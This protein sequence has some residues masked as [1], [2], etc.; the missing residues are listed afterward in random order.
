M[1]IRCQIRSHD[2]MLGH[3]AFVRV[4]NAFPAGSMVMDGMH[5]AMVMLG[6]ACQGVAEIVRQGIGVEL[7]DGSRAVEL[8]HGLQ[9]AVLQEQLVV[10]VQIEV[11]LAARRARVDRIEQDLQAHH[12]VVNGTAQVRQVQSAEQAV[13][14]GVVGL[15]F[16]Q[17]VQH[18]WRPVVFRQAMVTGGQGQHAL[19]HPV[20]LRKPHEKVAPDAAAHKRLADFPA[21]LAL[22]ALDHVAVEVCGRHRQ[23]PFVHFAVGGRRQVDHPAGPG[24]G[25]IVA[26]AHGMDDGGI[27][28]ALDEIPEPAFLV[29]PFVGFRPDAEFLDIVEIHRR[30]LPAFVGQAFEVTDHLVRR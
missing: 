22:F 27:Q 25:V 29:H 23:R 26:V 18:G 7:A 19:V 5:P 3:H 14:V 2:F 9:D 28:H 4:G 10:A 17:F 20:G 21:A 11:G 24:L 15:R 30:R 16:V 12:G 13:P 6:L 8:D 1:A